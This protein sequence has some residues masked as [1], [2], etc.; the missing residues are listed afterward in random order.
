[1]YFH[2]HP[3]G[4]IVIDTATGTYI[5][6]VDNFILDLGEPYPGIPAEYIGRWYEPGIDHHFYTSDTAFPQD[7]IWP[8]G[9]H[10]IAAC[11][12]LMAAKGQRENHQLK[13]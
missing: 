6:T 13:D 7:L 1:M 9:D 3:D 8:E 5:D 4:Y 10:Y 2:H 12:Q 11:D